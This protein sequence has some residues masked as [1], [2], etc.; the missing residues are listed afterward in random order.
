MSD[1]I[2]LARV[3][4][5]MG[6][7]TVLALTLSSTL[8]EPASAGVRRFDFEVLRNGSPIGSHVAVVD[9]R[10]GETVVQ[11]AVDFAVT[12][13]P[14]TLYRY[15]HRSTERWRDGRLA[16]IE[17]E[18]DDDGTKLSLRARAEGDRIVLDG[19]EGR[20]IGSADT[21]PSSYW[22]P[23]LRTAKTWIETHWGILGPVEIT[24]GAPVTVRLPGREVL[25][26]PHRIVSEKAEVTPVYTEEGEW[27]GLT[28]ELWG[29]RFDYVPRAS[30]AVTVAR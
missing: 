18:T 5:K 7:V 23:R 14:F 26:I 25:A 16:E 10:E 20:Q 12:F 13:G 11:V 3:S 28:F 27:V 6:R 19:P 22:N 2:S 17:A 21:L 8:T 15:K 29:A 9:E 30:S 4:R 24:K 1:P